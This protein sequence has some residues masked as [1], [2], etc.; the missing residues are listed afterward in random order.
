ME[1]KSKG[2]GRPKTRVTTTDRAAGKRTKDG[3]EKYIVIIKTPL[4]AKMKDLAYWERLTIKE[5]Y[6]EAIT[7]RI[8]RYEKKNGPV[9]S[10][11]KE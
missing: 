2:P 11:P 10:R 7:G 1:G 3:E 6:E 5:V 9:K 8:A 4:I